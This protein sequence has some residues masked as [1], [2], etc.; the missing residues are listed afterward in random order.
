M[1]EGVE[2]IARRL[3]ALFIVPPLLFSALDILFPLKVAEFERPS[4]AV[5]FDRN[6]NLLRVFLSDDDKWRIKKPLKEVSSELKRLVLLYEDRGFYRHPGVNPFSIARAA[7]QNISAGRIVSGG[8]TI[9]MQ[10]ARMI[11]PRERTVA[12]KLIESF[13]ALQ[14]ELNFTKDGILELYL[15]IA[16][17]GGNIEGAGAAALI[18]FGKDARELSLGEAALLAAIPNAPSKMRPDRFPQNALRAKDKLLN[19]LHNRGDIGEKEFKDA[20]AEPLLLD[21]KQ[22]PFLAP[23][24]TTILKNR[25]PESKRIV[26]TIDIQTQSVVEKIL[27]RHVESL[28]AK[29]ISQAS[30]VVIDNLT[31]EALALVGS[32]E[33]FEKE[34]SGQVNGFIA[35]RSPGSTL[36]PFVYALA[37]DRGLL[38]PSSMLADI[39]ISYGA[40]SPEN[41]DAKFRGVVSLETALKLSLN[42]PAVNT[43]A[44]L[45]KEGLYPFLKR[46]GVSTL[47]NP[48]SDYGLAMV[49]GGCE[50]NLLELT[51]LYSI[52]SRGGKFIP[53]KLVKGEEGE[54][55]QLLSPATAYIIT[56]ILAD[57]RR[58]DM[59][60]CW[61]FAPNIPKVAWKTGTSYGHK[62]AWSVGYN[63]RYSVGVWVGNFSGRGS[64]ELLGSEA[65]AP[66]LFEIFN[67]LPDVNAEDWFEPPDGVGEREVCGVSGMAKGEHC[68]V[69]VR[70]YYI[71]EVSPTKTCDMHIALDIDERTGNSLCSRC[72]EGK[73]HHKETFEIWGGDVAVWLKKN[74]YPVREIPPHNPD[75]RAPLSGGAPVI[76]SP[77]PDCEYFIR[78]GTPLEYQKIKLAASVGNDVE[79]LFWFIDG[80]LFFA[81]SP[82]DE[83]FYPPTLGRH[84]LLCADNYGRTS[85]VTLTVR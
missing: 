31:A 7:Y 12:A 74:G 78:E 9:T 22:M 53:Y 50:M 40:Y 77:Q 70:A 71:K 24:I 49:L 48:E 11:E 51:N 26:S 79:K 2:R 19:I 65:G 33:F 21:R 15:N 67:A 8:S 42:I 3:F 84:T 64:P 62:D 20:L 43:L 38:S 61:Q 73:E 10:V 6:G 56:E 76:K 81:G 52:F 14:I 13:R 83:V 23:H 39:P 36:K 25:Y 85:K 1:R 45:G 57:L 46:A 47:V 4:S 44:S 75:C 28:R 34:H 72:R 80:E 69:G 58:P 59:P 54:E 66:L 16:P 18:Y 82:E 60:N 30:V 17:Y 55:R 35:P 37:L 32:Y 63:R 41:F 68:P 27:K 5:V 29:G